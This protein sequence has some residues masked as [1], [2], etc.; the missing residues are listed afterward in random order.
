MYIL[1]REL[2]SYIPGMWCRWLMDQH[3]VN[4]A[5]CI[6]EGG[7]YTHKSDPIVSTNAVILVSRNSYNQK[8]V[9]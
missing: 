4:V 2:D 1:P 7:Q 8:R 3:L 9:L 6:H 5:S